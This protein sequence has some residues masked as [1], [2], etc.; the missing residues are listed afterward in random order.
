MNNNKT[1]GN[2]WDYMTNSC[3]KL[4]IIAT[5]V[6]A[7]ITN[8]IKIKINKTKPDIKWRIG[9]K[10]DKSSKIAQKKYKYR[11][12]CVD[13]RGNWDI[14]QMCGFK[15]TEKWYGHKPETVTKNKNYKILWDFPIKTDHTTEVRRLDIIIEIKIN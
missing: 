9:K 2:K 7:L 3:N 1:N 10:G 6:Q 14:S 13:N 4:K 15:T 12:S 5:E 11:H 8:V